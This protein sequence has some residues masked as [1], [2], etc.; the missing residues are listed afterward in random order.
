MPDDNPG[1]T[2]DMNLSASR[3]SR[4][5]ARRVRSALGVPRRLMR[6]LKVE[7]VRLSSEQALVVLPRAGLANRLRALASAHIMAEVTGRKLYVNW[8]S[9]PRDCNAAW[10]DLFAYQFPQ[11]F[12]PALFTS[13][14]LHKDVKLY[15]DWEALEFRPTDIV[16]DRQK[17]ILLRSSSWFKPNDISDEVYRAKKSQFYRSL[18]PIQSILAAVGKIE[19][20]YFQSHEVIGVHIRRKDLMPPGGSSWEVSPTYLFIHEMQKAVSRNSDVRF[21]L[22][23]DDRDEKLALKRLFGKRIIIREKADLQRSNTKA[24]QD[25]LIDWLL[26]SKTSLIIGSHWSSFSI[27]SA[28]VNRIPRISIQRSSPAVTAA[29]LR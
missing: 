7:A 4:T 16:A 29:E 19:E 9:H 22:A 21:F 10:R 20:A 3:S 18:R 15:D 1:R 14:G 25:A 28:E 6:R 11:Y 26:L 24:I 8:E 23:T 12:L 17:V 27:E 5:V 13:D 2:A